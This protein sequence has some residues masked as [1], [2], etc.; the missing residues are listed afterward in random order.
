MPCFARADSSYQQVSGIL[1]E[2]LDTSVGSVGG[3][4]R[5]RGVEVTFLKAVERQRY[6]NAVEDFNDLITHYGAKQVLED[7][8]ILNLTNY[9]ELVKI[10][11]RTDEVKKKTTAALLKDPYF[12]DAD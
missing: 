11:V 2:Q 9:E 5:N 10:V 8:K 6:L 1:I 4:G 3:F 12:R 7:L